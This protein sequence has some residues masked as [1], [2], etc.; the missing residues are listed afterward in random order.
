[1]RLNGSISGLCLDEAA[2]NGCINGHAM[3]RIG[4]VEGADTVPLLD[5]PIPLLP[6]PPLAPPLPPPLRLKDNEFGC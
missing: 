4:A 6:L 3:L 2:P 5:M 1:M